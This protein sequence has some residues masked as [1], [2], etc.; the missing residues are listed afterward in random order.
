MQ[1]SSRLQ[2]GVT[3]IE[4]LI[5]IVVLAVLLAVALPSYQG[6]MR[7]AARTEAKTALE[8]TA[9]R[10]EQY[11][12]ENQRY[13]KNISELGL[14]ATSDDNFATETNR[15]RITINT[16][17]SDFSDASALQFA[18]WSVSATPIGAQA[19]DEIIFWLDSRGNRQYQPQAGATLEPGWYD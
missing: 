4:V 1:T 9:S 10:L 13:S 11:F 2:T 6:Y 17:E 7:K 14:G 16:T 3:L 5:A 18:S 8:A 19:P 12:S 15:Y